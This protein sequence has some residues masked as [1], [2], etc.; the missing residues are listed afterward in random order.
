MS[1]KSQ[2]DPFELKTQ[3]CI[4]GMILNMSP[5]IQKEKGKMFT[6]FVCRCVYLI[7]LFFLHSYTLKNFHIEFILLFK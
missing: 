3:T 4:Y 6:S 2:H 7:F 5:K 1:N